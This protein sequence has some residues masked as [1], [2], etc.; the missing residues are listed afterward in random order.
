MTS[1][2]A[3]GGLVTSLGLTL[4]LLFASINAVTVTGLIEE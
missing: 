1:K 2:G 3:P 4:S